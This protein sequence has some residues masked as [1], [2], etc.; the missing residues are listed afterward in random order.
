MPF[1]SLFFAAFNAAHRIIQ[2]GTAK[3]RYTARQKSNI[4]ISRLLL[5]EF[6]SA[7]EGAAFLAHIH[8]EYGDQTDDHDRE[9]DGFHILAISK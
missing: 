4:C 2:V 6:V 9:G 8:G 7:K 3:T 5:I 1:W